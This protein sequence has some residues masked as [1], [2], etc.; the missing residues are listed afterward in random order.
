MLWYCKVPVTSSM[1]ITYFT[2][3]LQSDRHMQ[4]KKKHLEG[5]PELRNCTYRLFA[6][7]VYVTGIESLA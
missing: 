4:K 5:K 2:R 7:R 1:S 3:L 6:I